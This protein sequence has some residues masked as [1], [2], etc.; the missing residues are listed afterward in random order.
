MRRL[1][2]GPLLAWLATLR[3]PV[4]FGI[5]AVVFLI[6]LLVPDFIPFADEILL[7]LGTA[8]LANLKRDA[9]LPSR[10]GDAPRKDTPPTPPTR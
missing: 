4:L 10:D 1:L 6:D 3:F 8:L 7:G 9:L 2:L 5:T